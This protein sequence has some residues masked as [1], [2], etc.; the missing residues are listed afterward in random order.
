MNPMVK[1]VWR[2]P[3]LSIILFL[4]ALVLMGCI[5]SKAGGFS[6]YLLAGHDLRFGHLIMTR[7]Q[8]HADSH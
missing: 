6:I 1:K 8:I 7:T 4:T 5:P 3:A 2:L